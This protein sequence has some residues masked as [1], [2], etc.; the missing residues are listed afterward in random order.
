MKKGLS[1]LVAVLALVM[2]SCSKDDGDLL[3]MEP[4]GILLPIEQEYLDKGL[5]VDSYGTDMAVYPVT[6]IGFSYPQAMQ[7]I[8]SEASSR[9]ENLDSDEDQEAFYNELQQRMAVHQKLIGEL[10]VIPTKEYKSLMENPESGYEFITDMKIVAKKHG[11]T[12][13][14]SQIENTTDG[15][16]DEEA[17]IFFE[18]RD[19]ALEAVK[20]ARYKKIKIEKNTSTARMGEGLKFPMFTS[21]DLDGN[22]VT[23]QVFGRSDLTVLLLWN[24]E[25]KKCVDFVKEFSVWSGLLPENVQAVG[26]VCDINS[27]ADQSKM[28][29]AKRISEDAFTNI[30]AAGELQTVDEYFKSLPVVMLVDSDG[31]LWGSPVENPSLDDCAELVALWMEVATGHFDEE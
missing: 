4:C 13:L 24:H 28:D 5:T 9:W 21:L 31:D 18:C 30:I 12:Y 16:S 11:N 7:E 17:Q 10:A 6:I 20:N 19:H 8:Y 25:D 1:I 23:E 2:V 27:P 3:Y 15:M 26:M 22:S 14:F 29:S